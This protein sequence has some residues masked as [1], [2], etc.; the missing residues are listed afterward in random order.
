IRAANTRSAATAA[1]KSAAPS[2]AR[3]RTRRYHSA[4]KARKAPV[5]VAPR[6]WRHLGAVA[7]DEALEGRLQ[8]DALGHQRRDR[9]AGAHERLVQGG[10]VGVAGREDELVAAAGAGTALEGGA[11]DEAGEHAVGD[12]AR[13]GAHP[14]PRAAAL[15]QLVERGVR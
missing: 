5:M 6:S 14:E 1:T 7:L 13:S 3:L 9:T 8:R 2:T 15:Q 12:I 4:R 11:A 10:R